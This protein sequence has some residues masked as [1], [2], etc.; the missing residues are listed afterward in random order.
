MQVESLEGGGAVSE[1]RE[2]NTGLA[3][4]NNKLKYRIKHLKEVVDE[5]VLV[6]V[7]VNVCICS[8]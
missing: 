6:S 4:E 1:E 2:N 7:S 3:A 8:V 5:S